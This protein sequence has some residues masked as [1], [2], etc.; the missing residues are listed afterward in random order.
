M[1]LNRFAI[2][3]VVTAVAGPFSRGGLADDGVRIPPVVKKIRSRLPSGWSC[4][5]DH[6]CVVVSRNEPVIR[7]NLISLPR[8]ASDERLLR[9]FGIRTRYQIVLV[10]KP[11]LS[12]EELRELKALRAG[13]VERART[14]DD[15]KGSQSNRA[16]RKFDLPVYFDARFSIYVYR[17]DD[18]PISIYP[19]E[20]VAE[21]DAVLGVLDALFEK[22]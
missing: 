15:A 17:T 21:R 11:R 8:P 1:S 10:F 7:L 16:V 22:Y 12:E 14:I 4:E 20:A 3:A 2:V 5:G 19:K 6:T 18:G 9:E 13:V